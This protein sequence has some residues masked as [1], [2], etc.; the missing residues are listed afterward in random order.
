MINKLGVLFQIVERYMYVFLFYRKRKYLKELRRKKCSQT[1]NGSAEEYLETL[2]F[3]G[4]MKVSNYILVFSFTISLILEQLKSGWCENGLKSTVHMTMG[5]ERG[6]SVILPEEM[7]LLSGCLFMDVYRK[8][9]CFR[10]VIWKKVMWNVAA[11]IS[12]CLRNKKHL[13]SWLI[14]IFI[15][16][17]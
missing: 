5:S 12:R 2:T 9:C 10:F 3:C 15:K 17:H 16:S 13:N 4:L 1:A 6:S 7:S 14:F 11:C 8:C